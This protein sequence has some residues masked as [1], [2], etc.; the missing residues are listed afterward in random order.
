MSEGPGHRE[1]AVTSRLGGSGTTLSCH[2]SM[3]ID[4][5]PPKV[6]LQVVHRARLPH[7]GVAIGDRNPVP[8]Q[9]A[10]LWARRA[11]TAHRGLYLNSTKVLEPR[12]HSEGFVWII[13]FNPCVSIPLPILFSVPAASYTCEVLSAFEKWRSH[14]LC[15]N[16]YH[17]T[18]C[19]GFIF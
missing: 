17:W 7:M 8:T 13:S 14:E 5:R 10:K 18:P 12:Y 6:I 11:A 9:L 3:T 15:V 2:L 1:I 4:P 16:T 19:F